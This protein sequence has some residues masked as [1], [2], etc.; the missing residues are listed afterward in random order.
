MKTDASYSF[1]ASETATLKKQIEA[2]NNLFNREVHAVNG[3][4]LCICVGLRT[5]AAEI[6]LITLAVFAMLAGFN[7]TFV[8]NHSKTFM[9][10][11]F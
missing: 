5:G 9:V 4:A 6:T 1:S 3:L 7:L 11:L 2:M 8:A 10:T